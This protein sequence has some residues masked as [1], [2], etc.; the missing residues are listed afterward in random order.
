M[1]RKYDRKSR[2]FTLIEVL[3]A[4]VLTSLALLALAKL[5]LGSL[6]YSRRSLERSQALGLANSMLDAMRANRALALVGDYREAYGQGVPSTPQV[7]KGDIQYWNA[8]IKK[9]LPSAAGSIATSG[10]MA[11]VSIAWDC[12][13]LNGEPTSDCLRRINLKAQLQ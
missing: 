7:V 5:D 13:R 9:T 2:G 6:H 1:H 10:N 8:M 3:V 4:L 11:N 12:T